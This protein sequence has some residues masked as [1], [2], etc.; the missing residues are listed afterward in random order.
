MVFGAGGSFYVFGALRHFLVGF[1][2]RQL[3]WLVDGRGYGIGVFLRFFACCHFPVGHF[4]V[5]VLACEVRF[6]V[7]ELK[8]K[9]FSSCGVFRN[10]FI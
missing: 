7:P 3:F 4:Q 9:R 8:F 2:G 10:L 6:L 5:F 1:W